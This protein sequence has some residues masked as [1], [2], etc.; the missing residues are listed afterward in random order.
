[1]NTYIEINKIS[2]YSY[3]AGLGRPGL[4]GNQKRAPMSLQPLLVGPKMQHL[5]ALHQLQLP[6]QS[7]GSSKKSPGFRN[8]APEE[9]GPSAKTKDGPQDGCVWN[10][11]HFWGGN[12]WHHL[13][14]IKSL[15]TMHQH[16][17]RSLTHLLLCNGMVK[18]QKDLL[19]HP[20]SEKY[21]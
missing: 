18:M 8:E 16:G 7:G 1:M 4:G 2:T 19:Q 15:D 13:Q 10:E 17:C 6:D 9:R 3:E 21:C 5:Q 11:H 12:S 20:Q 14:R